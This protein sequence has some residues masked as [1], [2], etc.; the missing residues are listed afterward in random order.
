MQTAKL[1][2]ASWLK[3]PASSK[4]LEFSDKHLQIRN[5]KKLQVI[6]ILTLPLQSSIMRDYQLHILHSWKKIFGQFFFQTDWNL[7]VANIVTSLP[8]SPTKMPVKPTYRVHPEL[9]NGCGVEFINLLADSKRTFLDYGIERVHTSGR[10]SRHMI[11]SDVT[12]TARHH[13]LY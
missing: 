13:H 7:G 2:V 5:W 1:A 10:H 11:W 3:E 9:G 12:L 4:N 8:F 6:K